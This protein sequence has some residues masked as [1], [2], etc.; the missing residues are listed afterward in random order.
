M[1]GKQRRSSLG[2]DYLT[3]N[4]FSKYSLVQPAGFYLILE[5]Y[6]HADKAVLNGSLLPLERKIS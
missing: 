4:I 1:R 3:H 5:T 2:N 6:R